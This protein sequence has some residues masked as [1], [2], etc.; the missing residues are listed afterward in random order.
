MNGVE[1]IEWPYD[2]PDISFATT[3]IE[4]SDGV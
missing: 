3:E 4:D 1:A 2:A